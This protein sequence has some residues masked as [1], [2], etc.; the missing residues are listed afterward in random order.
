MS[1]GAVSLVVAGLIAMG[2]A[3]YHHWSEESTPMLA[4]AFIGLGYALVLGGLWAS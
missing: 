3:L 2:Y 4:H 1:A